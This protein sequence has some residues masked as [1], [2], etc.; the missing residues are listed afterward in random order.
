MKSNWL[1]EGSWSRYQFHAA[2][3]KDLTGKLLY[4]STAYGRLNE[5][6][7]CVTLLT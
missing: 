4:F 2:H 5:T 3:S 7:D 1:A 6:N